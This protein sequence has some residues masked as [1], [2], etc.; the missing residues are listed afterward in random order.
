MS[1]QKKLSHLD[2]T[3]DAAMVDVSQKRATSRR[4]EASCTILLNA[5]SYDIVQNNKAKKGNVL[6]VARIA[7]IM[8]A[9]KTS[10]LIPL[11]HQINLS[12]VAINFKLSESEK[13]I[14][15]SASTTTTDKTGVEMESL[16]ATSIASLT[17]YDMLKAVDKNIRITNIVLNFKDGGRSGTFIRKKPT[18]HK[19]Q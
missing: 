5:T 17:V 6:E 15:V 10:E 18:S 12:N 16:V 1:K 13:S 8:A 4:A 9:K 3:G 7:G 14:L 11:C 2:E 19:L